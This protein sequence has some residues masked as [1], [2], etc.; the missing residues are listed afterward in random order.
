MK[1]VILAP[2][3][4]YHI[5]CR[6]NN[7]APIF[8]AEKD[9]YRLL[10]TLLLFQSPLIIKHFKEIVDN[11]Y[12]NGFNFIDKKL[13]EE[14]IK[15]KIVELIGFSFMPNHFHLLLRQLGD[16][17]ITDYLKRVLNSYTKYLNIRHERTGHIFQGRFGRVLVET[18]EQLLYLLT[19][20]HRNCREL[21]QWKG[22]EEQYPWS[23]YQDYTLKN[24]W[25]DL[26]A[27]DVILEQ[28]VSPI[29]FKKFTETSIAKAYDLD[30]D[31]LFPSSSSYSSYSS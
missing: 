1:N 26:L 16:S 6:G 8:F 14:I 15:N 7:K 28:F 5:Y 30:S 27:T 24:R 19:Y 4:Y 3:E 20:I 9:R 25:G 21:P 22:K 10:L 29:E 2:G 18:N 13:I 17:G 23:S 11:F 31:I 12:K